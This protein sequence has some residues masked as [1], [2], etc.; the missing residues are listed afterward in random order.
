VEWQTGR[1]VEAQCRKR[2]LVRDAAKNWVSLPE[3]DLRIGAGGHVARFG[4]LAEHGAA[5]VDGHDGAGDEARVG[6]KEVVDHGGDLLATADAPERMQPPQLVIE[7]GV[8]ALGRDRAK[9]DR[10]DADA[11]RRVVDGKRPGEPLDR[12][13]GGGVGQRTGTARCAWCDET[14]TMAP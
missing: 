4:I 10:V 7:A 6:G 11:A 14:L 9:G 3:R 1:S 8:V 2:I 12:C 5:T 13:L